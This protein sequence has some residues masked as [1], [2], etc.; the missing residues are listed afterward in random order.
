MNMVRNADKAGS[1]Y[2]ADP[3]ALAAEVDECVRCARAEY[4][5]AMDRAEGEPAAI[6]VPHAG[7]FFSGAVAAAGFELVRERL[8]SVDTFVVFGACHRA[9]LREPAIWPEGSWRTPLGDI[10]IDAGLAGA[11][12]AGG[13]GSANPDVHHG[14][15]AIELQAPFIKRLFPGAKM[16]PA[17]MGFFRDSWKLGALAAAIAAKRGGTVV[18]VASCDLTH[19][20]ASFGVMPAGTG[21][22]ALEWTRANDA[23]L[24]DAMVN[25]DLDDIVPTAERDGSACGAGAAAAS[26]GWGK[27]RGCD[28]GTLLAYTN[29]YEVMPQGEAEHLVGYAAI[30]YSS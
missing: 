22:A 28:S 20:G 12:V 11:L 18:A 9:R 4:G 13:F 25:M 21:R 6:L 30:S 1:W 5:A 7:L 15:N 29:S 14:D 24:I 27:V 19:Y 3:K 2:A 10:E 8:G 23:R 26:A 16:V 17:A